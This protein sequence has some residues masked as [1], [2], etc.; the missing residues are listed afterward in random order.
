MSSATSNTSSPATPLPTQ[1]APPK[2]YDDLLDEFLEEDSDDV[3][4]VFGRVEADLAPGFLNSDQDNS[5]NT[6]SPPAVQ[7]GLENASDTYS[8]NT[9]QIQRVTRVSVDRAARRAKLQP[10]QLAE[11]DTFMKVSF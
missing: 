3:E 11:V 10:Y 9:P 1:V 6:A 7:A 5:A 4:D 8:L 2:T